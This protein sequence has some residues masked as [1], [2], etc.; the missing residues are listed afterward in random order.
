MQHDV[1]RVNLDKG[2]TKQSDPALIENTKFASRLRAQTSIGQHRSQAA[3]D[4]RLTRMR[5]PNSIHKQDEGLPGNF[6]YLKSN[7]DYVEQDTE[8]NFQANNLSEL[9]KASDE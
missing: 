5:H 7:D 6:Y 2:V 4:M 3:L 8:K 1:R 9:I